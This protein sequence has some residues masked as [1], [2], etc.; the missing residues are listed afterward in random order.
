MYFILNPLQK[1]KY[2]N[3]GMINV[4]A[5]F[6][7]E[8]DDEGYEKYISEHLVSLPIIPEGGY[9]GKVNEEGNPVD[10]SDYDKWIQSL[11]TVQQLNSFCNHSIQFEYDVTEEEILWCF[12]FALGITARNYLIDDLHCK[13]GGQVVNQPFGYSERRVAYQIIDSEKESKIANAESKVT[14]LSSLEFKTIKT[15]DKYSVR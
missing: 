14:V 8:E 9:P 11:P 15:I 3:M 10:Q 2:T 1:D 12:E 13:S 7:L 5:D 4:S 6:Y